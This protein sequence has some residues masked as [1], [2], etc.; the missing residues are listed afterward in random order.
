LKLGSN[1]LDARE[2]CFYFQICESSAK[3]RI[4]VQAECHELAGPE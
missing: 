1:F 3:V 2:H 4:L